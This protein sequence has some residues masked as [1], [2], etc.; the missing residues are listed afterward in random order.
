MAT[1]YDGHM[2]SV[3]LLVAATSGGWRGALTVLATL[4]LVGGSF[5]VV[6][7]ID[8]QA[9]PDRQ[10]PPHRHAPVDLGG[11]DERP[12]VDAWPLRRVPDAAGPA[13]RAA[14]PSRARSVEVGAVGLVA[15]VAVA[16]ALSP[17]RSHIGQASAALSLV[18]VVIGAA[19][20]G[21]RIAAAV[22]S[23][24]AA[25]GFNFFHVPPVHSFHIAATSAVVTSVLMIAVGVA[26]GEL[27]DRNP[28]DV[29]GRKEGATR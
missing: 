28:R 22:T 19:A 9:S 29:P 17:L 21:G 8:R 11:A 20:L 27:A 5:V 7:L 14:R 23:A 15:A 4:A 12:G 6:E 3:G 13:R 18:L 10:I 25:L 24:A 16:A 2:T 26:V 1:A